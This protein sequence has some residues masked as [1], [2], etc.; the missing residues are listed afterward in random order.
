MLPVPIKTVITAFR[1]LMLI[2]PE[3][4]TIQ[5]IKETV[6]PFLEQ[7]HGLNIHYDIVRTGRKVWVSAYVTFDKDEISLS[8]LTSIQ[9]QCIEAL[10]NKDTDYGFEL[11]PEM[12]EAGEPA[13]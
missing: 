3:E 6:E 4:D 7:C 5:E 13:L 2:P 1:D 8:K 12:K 11:I 10:R 9:K